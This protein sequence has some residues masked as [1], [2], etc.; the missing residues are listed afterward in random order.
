MGNQGP[1][2]THRL[3]RDG[4]LITKTYRSWS[5]GEHRREWWTLNQLADYQP[6]LAPQPISADLEATPPSITMTVLPGRPITGIW[7]GD[8]LGLL[9]DAMR[10]LWSTPCDGLEPIDV[11]HPGY[12]RALAGSSVRPP[13]GAERQAYDLAAAWIDSPDLDALLDSSQLRIL[14]QGDP[15]PGNMIYDGVRIRLVDFEDAGASD[16]DFEL[17]NFAEHLGTRGTGLD[18]L[19][20][21]FEVD[22]RRYQFCRRLLAS[23]WLF[24]LLPDPEGIRPPRT[25]ELHD[26]A[27][28]LIDLFS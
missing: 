25:A 18:Q 28:R 14:G 7:S 24:T 23:F 1:R 11:H 20:A 22:E 27:L 2:Q 5:R 4:D 6:G 8:Q 26:Q 10:S 12:W 21:H 9:G 19:V 17:A 16:P 15:Q 13:L 3:D